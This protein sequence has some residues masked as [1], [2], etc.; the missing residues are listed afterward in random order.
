MVRRA[1][2]VT[3]LVALAASP[4]AAQER[5]PSR[6]VTLISPQ[7]PGTAMDVLARLYAE[8]LP[9]SIGGAFVVLNRPGG[10]GVV[11]AQAV[12]TAAPD[13]YTLVT[14]NSGHAILGVLNKNLPFDP[15]RDFAG[16]AM[17]GETPALI[18]VTP[19]LGVHTLQEFVALARAK[20]GTINYGSAG[21]GTSTHIAGA[22]FAYKAGIE[23]VHVPYKSGSELIADLVA[24]RIQAT[25]SP[26]AFV[27]AMV[28]EGKLLPLAVSSP[29][30]MRDPVEVPSARMAGI[31]Y[32]YSTWYGFMAPA[33]TPP[34]ILETLARA[35]AT[36]GEDPVLGAKVS[37]QGITPRIKTGRAFDAHVRDEVARL[38]PVLDAVGSKLKD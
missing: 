30:A 16:I 32:D 11:A 18:V 6:T 33:K 19:A 22:Y 35:I 29:E 2:T 31:D 15:L 12:A 28:R 14:A 9:H 27:L 5:Y 23:M 38:G 25:F 37:M 34:A 21:V 24:G 17:V 20:P 26:P 8:A 7:S 3:V 4:V 13:G 1:A 36:A 10:G